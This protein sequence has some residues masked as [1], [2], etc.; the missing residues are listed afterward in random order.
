MEK[1]RYFGARGDALTI[2]VTVCC[3]TAMTLF[4]YDQAVFSGVIISDDFLRVMGH[5]SANM[6]ATITSLYDVGCFFGSVAG[7]VFGSQLGRKPSV[8]W[9]T[10]VMILGAVL[11]ISAFSV[12]QMIV[13]RLVAGLGNGLNTATAPVW[14]SETTKPTWRGKLVVLG[15]V[16]N[17]GGFCIANWVA[18]GFSYLAGGIAWRFPLALQL[19]FGIVIL[20]TAPWLPE[21][22]RWLI[23]KDRIEEAT[24]VLADVH[25]GGATPLTP[26][27]VAERNEILHAYRAERDNAV[28]WGDL[29]RNRTRDNG[30][31]TLRRFV[32]G[33]GT[34]I[35]VQLSGVNATSYYLPTVLTASVGLP[36]RLARLLTAANGIHYTFFSFLGMMLIDKWGRRGAMLFGTTGCA[37]CYLALTLLIWAGSSTTSS[38]M[39]HEYG[40]AA[41]SMIFLYY[42]FFGT[43]WQGT[44]WLYNT[45]I[46]SLHMRMKGASASVAAQWA[47]NYMVVQVTPPGIQNLGWRFYLIWLF[48]NWFSIPVLY[49]FYPETANRRL[50]DIDTVF[51]EGL[52]VWAFTNREA[53]QVR[54]PERFIAMD[55]QEEEAAT[56]EIKGEA[57]QLEHV[58]QKI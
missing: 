40:A 37:C 22:P 8:I 7:S 16:V 6:V 51:K 3:A 33:L 46:N 35:I 53:I 49:I 48:F 47:V 29:L 19:L 39:Q 10:V 42:A 23:S 26:V 25:G 4:G 21:S 44:A 32:L 5:P 43:G 41:V 57:V 11:Q 38:G 28:S 15:L 56:I 9:G 58:D 20:C 17:V 27:V 54:R 18:F 36:D 14:Q 45:E 31:G 50:E 12:P 24:Q 52:S 13:G 2:W 30:Q 55:L 34:Q 1:D